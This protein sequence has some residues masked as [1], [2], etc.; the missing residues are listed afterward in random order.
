LKVVVVVV[1]VVVVTL[2]GIPYVQTGRHRWMCIM[3]YRK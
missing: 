1:V 3:Q 2:L